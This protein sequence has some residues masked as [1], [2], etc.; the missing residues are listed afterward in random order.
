MAVIKLVSK[1][2]VR[3]GDGPSNEE[4]FSRKISGLFLKA[5]FMKA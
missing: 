5:N 2:G 4:F 1:R 3:K